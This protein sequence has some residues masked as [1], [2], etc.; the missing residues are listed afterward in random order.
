MS[1]VFERD[2]LARKRFARCRLETRFEKG[3]RTE[4]SDGTTT[5]TTTTTFVR[6]LT[7]TTV[8]ILQTEG[9]VWCLQRTSAEI[10][11]NGRNR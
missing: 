6:T 7:T 1:T 11:M 10:Q 9:I 4:Y 2:A 3:L 5:T 8:N